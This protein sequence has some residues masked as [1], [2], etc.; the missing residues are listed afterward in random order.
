MTFYVTK[1]GDQVSIIFP[2]AMVFISRG[3]ANFGLSLGLTFG[4][5]SF[6]DVWSGAWL[7]G[8]KAILV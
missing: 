5:L 1:T 7:L 2:T 6:L 8:V 3:E 4:L